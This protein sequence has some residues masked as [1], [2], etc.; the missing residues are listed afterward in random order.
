MPRVRSLTG[1]RERQV[2]RNAQRL[3]RNL[4]VNARGVYS[5]KR[6]DND[7]NEIDLRDD[8]KCALRE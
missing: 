1:R 8:F 6:I 5:N 3:R 2:D 7:F 4:N